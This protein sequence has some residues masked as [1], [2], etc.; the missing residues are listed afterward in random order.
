M[1]TLAYIV[2]GFC[3]GWVVRRTS[4]DLTDMECVAVIFFIFL[5]AQGLRAIVFG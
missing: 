1:E 2:A 4:P 3:T 5:L